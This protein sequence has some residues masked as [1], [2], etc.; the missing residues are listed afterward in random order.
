MAQFAESLL[1]ICNYSGLTFSNDLR[2][3]SVVRV[4]LVQEVRSLSKPPKKLV[5][6]RE[7]IRAVYAQGE[8]AVIALVEGLL[9]RMADLEQRV[10]TLEHQLKKD[11]RNRSKPP[12]SDGFGRRTKA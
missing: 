11:S 9:H 7:E 4:A 5:I 1:K 8:E 2:S 6:S 3:A 12:A 10:E